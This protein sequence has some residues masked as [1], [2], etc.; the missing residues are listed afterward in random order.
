MAGA[1]PA[2]YPALWTAASL[3]RK[4]EVRQLLAQ[5][6][7][8]EERGGPKHSTPLEIA[9]LS[10]HGG[11]VRQ[12]LE[13]GAEMSAN[14][15]HGREPLRE[16]HRCCLWRSG[17]HRRAE[18]RRRCGSCSHRTPTSRR[19]AA[20]GNPRRFTKLRWKATSK[21]CGCFSRPAPTRHAP[22]TM[23]GPRC[24]S[25]RTRDASRQRSCCF[26]PAR[27]SR[28]RTTTEALPCGCG[29]ARGC[30]AAAHRARRRRLGRE[31]R[32]GDAAE[33][34]ARPRPPGGGEAAAA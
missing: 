33:P 28:P 32:R 8:L 26:S 25:L 27:R 16:R 7:D 5:D 29:R 1:I 14:P 24:M 30:G 11:V 2:R 10:G 18:R 22:P 17:P 4:E 20:R 23:A 21:C 19:Q 9:V 31:Q 12:L 3:G 13:A 34:R 15:R 6:P